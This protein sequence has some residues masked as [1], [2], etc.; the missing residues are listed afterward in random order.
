LI[1]WLPDGRILVVTERFFGGRTLYSILPDGTGQTALTEKSQVVGDALLSPDKTL[2]A[3]KTVGGLIVKDLKTNSVR[4]S[5]NP[6]GVY[7]AAWSPDSKKLA[8]SAHGIYILD[9]ETLSGVSVPVSANKPNYSPI[10]PLVSELVWSPD[11]KK[12][13]YSMAFDLGLNRPSRNELWVVNADG[14][15]SRQLTTETQMPMW[16]PNG[17]Y[18]IFSR[19]Q[20]RLYL[21]KADGSGERYIAKGVYP[22]WIP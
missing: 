10:G 19:P 4:Y 22:Q 16:S 11:G 12:I 3:I 6:E 9:L 7:A 18:I 1:G 13:A 14:S 8:Y 15:G 2:I 20:A 21:I 5:G 17:R